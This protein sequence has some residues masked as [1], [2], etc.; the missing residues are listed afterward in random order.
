MTIG[1][2]DDAERGLGAEV[3]FVVEAVHHLHH[4]LGGQA[5]IL[6]V[7]HL[8]AA[9]VRHLLVGDQVVVLGVVVELGAGVGMRDRDLNGLAVE[10]LGEVDRVAD[11]LRRFAGKTDDE[12]AVDDQAEL[13][14]VLGEA[15]AARR[16]RPS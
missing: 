8:V 3:V 12:V 6:D 10:R 9:V 14:A 1:L 11:R 7:R 13:V 15:R 5:G 4:V 16:W 2:P